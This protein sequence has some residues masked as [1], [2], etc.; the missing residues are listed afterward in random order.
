MQRGLLARLLWPVAL[1]NLAVLQELRAQPGI[2]PV[3]TNT[4]SW[5]GY[6]AIGPPLFPRKNGEST[7]CYSAFN[8]LTGAACTAYDS[9]TLPLQMHN[10]VHPGA[11][12]SGTLVLHRTAVA[13]LQGLE[14]LGTAIYRLRVMGPDGMWLLEPAYCRPDLALATYS[15]PGPGRYSVEVLMLYTSFSFAA[16]NTSKA[17][18]QPWAG[19]LTLDQQLQRPLVQAWSVAPDASILAAPAAGEAASAS[20]SSASSSSSSSSSSLPLCPDSGP[21]PGRWRFRTWPA[22]EDVA[23][24]LRTCIWGDPEHD[25]ARPERRGI[26]TASHPGTLYW[27]PDACRMRSFAGM[28]AAMASAAAAAAAAEAAGATAD[29][30]SNSG[31]TGGDSSAGRP[32]R[33]VQWREKHGEEVEGGGGADGE[34]EEAA[35]I[36]PAQCLPPGRRV[37][38]LGDSH[39]R[40]LH[41]SLV[42]WETGFVRA[43]DNSIKELLAS[44]TNTSV[45]FRMLWGHDWPEPEQPLPGSGDA[46]S[47]SSSSSGGGGGLDPV[48]AAGCTDVFANFGQWPASYR[49]G[50]APFSAGQYAAQVAHVRRKLAA[51]RA[52]HGVRVYWVTTV[53]SSLKARLE[54]AGIDWRTDPQLL[55]YNRIAA[56]IMEG[57]VP[58]R[59]SSSGNAAGADDS[60]ATAGG[61]RATRDDGRDQGQAE[62]DRGAHWQR[63]LQAQRQQQA[64][65]Q[66]LGLALDIRDTAPEEVE[67]EEE[68][69]EEEAEEDEA[70]ELEEVEDEE[71]E[72]EGEELEDKGEHGASKVMEHL[73]ALLS[74][75]QATGGGEGVEGATRSGAQA[76]ASTAGISAAEL[77]LAAPVRARRRR[78]RQ[79]RRRTQEVL[80]W[81]RAPAAAA[82]KGGSGGSSGGGASGAGAAHQRLLAML[83]LPLPSRRAALDSGEGEL[84]AATTGGGGGGARHQAGQLPARSLGADADSSGSGASA[85]PTAG[86]QQGADAP[87]PVIDTFSA[88]RILHEATW[89]GIHYTNRGLGGELQV[90]A[91]LH[92][93]CGAAAVGGDR[94]GPSAAGGVGAEAEQ[95]DAIKPQ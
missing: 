53:V 85:G 86:L 14:P 74:S 52:A 16:P 32:G 46:S 93:L 80:L 8:S 11:T 73:R 49:S 45:Y 4:T 41:N 89:D 22:A 7:T 12:A 66:G 37:C 59:S 75:L 57:T 6:L 84:E 43:P 91:V 81:G 39:A 90:T 94:A 20:V 82:G 35:A 29:G 48:V 58:H 38:F 92:A 47:S 15:L 30:S 67:D 1:L 79:Q 26:H 78:L 17:M 68:D 33:G 95:R 25:C 60:E 36:T 27:Q 23:P 50:P 72:A 51:L 40:Y 5:P 63:Q 87:I 2:D 28:Q 42:M 54:S 77:Q 21:Q 88:T 44:P 24:L 13:G 69:E 71:E 56:D 55:L 65:A 34:G 3:N 70:A 64:R 62:A 31:S 61:R 9:Q 76:G 10:C 19:Y 18:S 83:P